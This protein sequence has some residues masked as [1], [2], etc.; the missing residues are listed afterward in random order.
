MIFTDLQ[1]GDAVFLDANTLIYHFTNNPKYGAACTTLLDRIEHQELQGFTSSDCLADHGGHG[2]A[3]QQRP[4]GR[5]L[6]GPA[7]PAGR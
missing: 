4:L 1:V 6:A 5:G 2:A 7:A 3:G